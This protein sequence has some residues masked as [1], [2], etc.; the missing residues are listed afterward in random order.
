M[1]GVGG[2]Q[3]LRRGLVLLEWGTGA[4]GVPS[5][6]RVLVAVVLPLGD[7]TIFVGGLAQATPRVVVSTRPGGAGHRLTDPPTSLPRLSLEHLGRESPDVSVVK[8]GLSVGVTN[9]IDM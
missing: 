2:R 1:A 4:I 9:F 8:S 5:V 3:G 7:C 6:P